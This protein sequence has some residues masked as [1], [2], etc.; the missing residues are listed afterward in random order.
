MSD[1]DG[2][3]TTPAWAPELAE[4]ERRAQL[5]AAMG[6]AEAVAR[7]RAQ[8]RLTIRERIERLC[9]QGSFNEIGR[10]TAHAAYGPDGELHS[11]T[12]ANYL[13]GGARIDERRVVI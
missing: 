13:F 7:H 2:R 12:P 3:D 1:L 10:L 6:G 4:L 9:D 5:G 8:G 11:L